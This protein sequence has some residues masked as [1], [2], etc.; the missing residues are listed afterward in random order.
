MKILRKDVLAMQTAIRLA[1]CM[2]VTISSNIDRGGRG[3]GFSSG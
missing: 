1:V 2:R 3:R